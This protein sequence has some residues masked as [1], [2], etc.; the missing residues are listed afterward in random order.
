MY[1]FFCFLGRISVQAGD[2]AGH[3]N[4]TGIAGVRA[5]HDR[6]EKSEKSEKE[7]QT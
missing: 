5:T 6:S 2:S 4:Q 7:V 3:G 1:L